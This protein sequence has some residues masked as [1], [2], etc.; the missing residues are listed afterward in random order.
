MPEYI[1]IK[2]RADDEKPREKL[3]NNGKQSLSNAE[4][5]G[6]LI[7]T[8]T[9]N[10]SAIDL[11]R[12]ILTAADNNLH[13]LARFTVADLCKINGIGPAKAITIISAIELG[14]RKNAEQALQ[15]KKISSSEQIYRYI[16]HR[17]AYLHHEEFWIVLL[18][19]ANII[20]G[21][22]RISEGG[23]SAT[24]VDPKKVFKQVLEKNAS[25]IILCHNHPSGGLKPSQADKDITKKITNA[26]LLLDINVLDHLIVTPTSYFSFADEGLI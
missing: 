14:G 8:G 18:N 23:V 12:D 5:L 19:H 7:G 1:A 11:A 6:I 22:H 16:N 25:S 13:N 21:E 20:I 3:Q 10:R 17:L 2:N 4:L 26:G 9:K 24:V 15:V